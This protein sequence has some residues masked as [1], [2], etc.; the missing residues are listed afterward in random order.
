[1][2]L[3]SK[4]APKEEIL[5]EILRCAQTITER[6]IDAS[7]TKVAW[8]VM[9]LSES[10]SQALF[11]VALEVDNGGDPTDGLESRLNFLV[12]RLAMSLK[13]QNARRIND[14]YAF[15]TLEDGDPN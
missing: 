3:Q 9:V 4:D 5:A 10:L 6:H 7:A 15:L 13:E 11:N 8:A 2:K 1:M 12:D 14:L